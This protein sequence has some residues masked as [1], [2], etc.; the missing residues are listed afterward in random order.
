VE[1]LADLDELSLR[2]RDDRAK[3]YISEAIASYRAGAYRAAIVTTWVAVAFDVIEKLREL[4]LQGD[5]RASPVYKT[6]EAYQDQIQ[7][8][9]KTAISKALEFERLLLEKARDDLQL[10]D[11]QQFIDLERLR[12]DRNRAA[13]PTF[14]KAEVPYYP[15]AELVRTHI[16]HAIGH[17]LSQPPVQGKAALDEL[18]KLVTSQFFPFEREKVKQ[19]LDNSVFARPS[20]SLINSFVDYLLTSSLDE[21]HALFRKMKVVSILQY[22][23]DRH[24]AS[25]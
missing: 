4:S 21:K 11:Q 3:S 1:R 5:A 14:Q 17:L 19:E 25:V 18:H 24:R 7:R 10:I 8:G 23:L 15:N 9:D 16:R 22:T 6:F 20:A 12:E 13:H 2:C